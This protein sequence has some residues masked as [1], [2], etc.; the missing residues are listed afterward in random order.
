MLARLRQPGG[1]LGA[2]SLTAAVL[3]GVVGVAGVLAMLIAAAVGSD[4]WADQRSI[5]FVSALFFA[6]VAAGAAGFLIM[7]RQP[8]L[9]AVL[10]VLGSLAFAFILWWAILPLVLGLVF[11]VVAI[12]RAQKFNEGLSHSQDHATA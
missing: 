11:T 7:D 10:A 8:W 3:L 9:G 5:Q 12:V 4:F 6:V 2:L 1:V